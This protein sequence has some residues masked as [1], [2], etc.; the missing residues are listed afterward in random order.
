MLLSACACAHTDIMLK[1][2][3]LDLAQVFRVNIRASVF[4]C[5][6]VCDQHSVASAHSGHRC[7]VCGQDSERFH[8]KRVVTL[9][10]VVA[11]L[12]KIRVRKEC[13][14]PARAGD[15]Y[16]GREQESHQPGQSA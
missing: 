8:S 2:A 11:S 4:V 7:G 10:G 9:M 5:E 15:G 12:S 13:R 6:Y 1:N 14:Q 3:N 16:R